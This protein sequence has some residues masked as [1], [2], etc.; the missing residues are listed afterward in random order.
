MRSRRRTSTQGS[1][2]FPGHDGP[3][4]RGPLRTARAPRP[5][6]TPSSG[7]RIVIR[8]PRTARPHVGN[9]TG[10]ADD[11]RVRPTRR[12]LL[13]LGGAG[14]GALVLSACSAARAI[15]SS[16]RTRRSRSSRYGPVTRVASTPVNSTVANSLVRSR[17]SRW[18]RPTPAAPPS[19]TA[20][21]TPDAVCAT[22]T[23]TSADAASRTTS[24][25]TRSS[26][27]YPVRHS[28]GK[29]ATAAPAS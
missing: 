18:W 28:S 16:D 26:I 8:P 23:S 10:A 12:A 17:L 25:I 4:L 15:I 27:A 21:S 20:S 29:R 7:E 2:S 11:A 19:T 3:R 5:F 24:C 13:S 1:T 14:L 6:R 22:T 9:A